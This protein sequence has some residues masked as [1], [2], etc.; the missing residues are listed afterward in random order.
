MLTVERDQAFRRIDA[1]PRRVWTAEA[2]ER[3]IDYYTRALKMPHGQQ[4]L[5]AVQ[6]QAL[7]ETIEQRGFFGPMSV[8]TG[9][10]LYSILAP[11]V[12]GAKRPLL[13][14][15]GSLVHKT[16][17]EMTNLASHW[18]LPSNLVIE[19]YDKLS[20]ADY[21]NMISDVIK[22]DLI[23]ADEAHRL[24]NLDASCTKRVGRYLESNLTCMFAAISGTIFSRELKD[25]AHLI[26]WALRERSPI[27][28]ETDTLNIWN[29]ALDD[30]VVI[31]VDPGPLLD[32]APPGEYRSKREKAR[33]G[34]RSRVTQSPG[35]VVS[36][37]DGYNGALYIRG[38][39]IKVPA[40]VEGYYQKLRN[41]WLTPD[42]WE[43][44]LPT[45]VRQHARE[46]AL[47]LHYIWD[48]RPPKDWREARKTW[49]KIARD[50]CGRSGVYD[51]EEQ[52]SRAIRSGELKDALAARTLDR[53]KDVEPTFIPNV[54]PVWHDTGALEFCE[55]WANKPGIIWV[56]H[57]HFA[58]ELSNR[59]AI[60]YYAQNGIDQLTGRFIEDCS[61][62]DAVI[63][64]VGSNCTGRNLQGIWNRNLITSIEGNLRTEQ[65]IGR[66]H[67]SG[68]VKDEVTLDV[69]YSCRENITSL[70]M[71]RRLAKEAQDILGA[72]HKLVAATLEDWPSLHTLDRMQG[73]QYTRGESLDTDTVLDLLGEIENE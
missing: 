44:I 67:R 24:K 40:K 6:A 23:I 59:T 14:L 65:L 3:A 48:P 46:L 32:W 52:L 39:E 13:L 2:T 8:G 7:H 71:A 45:Q 57:R 38:H 61:P 43:L 21:V 16:R 4:R 5:R 72:K 68:Q 55:K 53:W 50:Y 41:E 1:L 62:K 22:P 37:E 60:P 47:G 33:I 18:S 31:G 10:T 54:V 27:P 63:A 20:R 25:F 9:K 17:R 19:S 56:E 30:S 36:L 49:K 28:Y 70:H 35:V 66:T 64:S 42:D 73:A 29:S 69:L 11:V 34:I 15:P 58:I 51:S 12:L 26:A